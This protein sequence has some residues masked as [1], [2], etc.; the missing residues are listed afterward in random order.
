MSEPTERELEVKRLTEAM[1][2]AFVGQPRAEVERRLVETYEILERLTSPELA[3]Q[4]YQELA[5]T[6][7]LHRRQR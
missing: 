4:V 7:D 6:Y 5:A 3:K 2:A 1:V